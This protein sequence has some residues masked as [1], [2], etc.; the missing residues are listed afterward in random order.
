MHLGLI[1]EC[2]YREGTTQEEAFEEAFAQ[3]ELAETYGLDGVW[4][5]ERHFAA[6][7]RA[8][9]AFG[10]GIPSIASVPLIL[11]SA[12]AAR[13][14]RLRIGTAVSV[15]P[16][17]HPIRTAEEAATIDQI[18]KGRLDF[19]VGRSGFP[20]S[21]KGYAIPYEESRG[22]FREYLEVILKAWTEERFSYEGQYYSCTDLCVLP[23]PYQKPSPPIRVAATTQETFPQVGQMGYPVFV[24][25]RG[26]DVPQV[27]RHLTVYRQTLQ[28]AGH[29]GQG[30]VFLRIPV[31]VAE[32][33]DRAYNEPQAST[34]R[35]YQRLARTFAQ[36]VGA[37][38]TTST[39]ERQERAS[40]LAQVSYDD[41]LRDRLAYGTPDMVVE[42][43]T[44]L[45]QELGLSGVV[46]EPNVGG[47]ISRDQVWRSVRLFA[48]EV[49]PRLR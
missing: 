32:T 37:A 12:I 3:V 6:P 15:L 31:Y 11:A 22:R 7:R 25:L 40:T 21:Y 49:A 35:S 4:L 41:L 13:T 1:M 43:L 17:C 23:K 48:Q 38:G 5:A 16:L 45:R 14:T 29:A 34:L 27:A 46:I 47:G 36:S 28:E 33:A 42:R 24:G 26:F 18:S 19:G 8:L 9:D 30:D 44:Q 2:D 39:E 20:T 10:A